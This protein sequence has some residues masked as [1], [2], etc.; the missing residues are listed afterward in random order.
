MLYLTVH[1]IRVRYNEVL[2]NSI[3][4]SVELLNFSFSQYVYVPV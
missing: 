3:V 2:L 4:G 1:L